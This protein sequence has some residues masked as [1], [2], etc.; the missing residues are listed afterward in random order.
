MTLRIDKLKVAH[1]PIVAVNGFSAVVEPGKVIAVIGPNGA[2][3]SSL[4]AAIGGQLPHDGS[5][6]LGGTR[7]DGM[8][9]HKRAHAGLG[10]VPSGRGVF[11]SISVR[12]HVRM[13][14]GPRD[15]ETWDRLVGWFPIL[16]D[17]QDA[18]GSNLSGGQQQIVS[19]AR[20]MAADPKFLL[21][22]EPSI[23]LSPIATDQLTAAVRTLARQNVGILLT[24]QN[25]GLALKLS[26]FCILMV[27]GDTYL[28]G[29]PEELK[30]R[31]EI[32]AL[33]LGREVESAG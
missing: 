27:R 1:G 8:P 10:F 29:R 33:Y 2:G 21:M 9:S 24:E 19:I 17:K 14:A 20:A 26:D 25:A 12:D 13:S 22:D 31:P 16:A 3:K 5:V 32:E 18:L 30:D 15:K 6:E 23:G 4:L 7:L 11:P 28:S